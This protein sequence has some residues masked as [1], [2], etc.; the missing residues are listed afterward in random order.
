MDNSLP[1]II[2]NNDNYFS[3]MEM[4]YDGITEK[5]K[6]IFD[7]VEYLLGNVDNE[8]INM[9]DMIDGLTHIRRMV[10]PN[11]KIEQDEECENCDKHK[12]RN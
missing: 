2:L 1:K 6:E 9:E 11:S 10:I 5:E 12:F 3:R 8:F 7:I 4:I